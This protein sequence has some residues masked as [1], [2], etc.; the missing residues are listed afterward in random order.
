MKVVSNIKDF[1]KQMAKPNF[2]SFRK[3]NDN[4]ALIIL[5]QKA[6]LTRPLPAAL[7]CLDLAKLIMYEFHKI[8]RSYLNKSRILF[9]DTDSFL[10]YAETENIYK[11]LL[12]V[13]RYLD[14]SN[15]HENHELFSSRDKLVPGLFKDE[16][17]IR[18]ITF[19]EVPMIFVGLKPKMYMIYSNYDHYY[20]KSKGVGGSKAKKYKL[21]DFINALLNGT[22]QKERITSIRSRDAQIFTEQS[23]K[24]TLNPFDDKRYFINQIF[25]L[26]FGY[27]G[28]SN[29]PTAHLA[30]D[31][32]CIGDG[33]LI[34][35]GEV[36][37]GIAP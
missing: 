7:C 9:S 21:Q 8:T 17:P 14:T 19:P 36:S 10:L 37:G 13:L 32:I 4:V 3:L 16:F 5:E 1:D 15:Y 20:I 22:C 11:D 33:E 34:H 23:I 12:P 26:P 24:M 31:E 30:S 25:S 28:L 35:T 27:F 29:P 6:K 2:K 18:N